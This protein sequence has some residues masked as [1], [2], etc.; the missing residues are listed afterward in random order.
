MSPNE[1]AALQWLLY[2]ASKELGS[3]RRLCKM[4]GSA[5]YIQARSQ[6]VDKDGAKTA[7]AEATQWARDLLFTE[8]DQLS[9]LLD[10]AYGD[11]E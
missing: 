7:A 9:A 11:D 4:I 1:L 5:R 6:G 10:D 2:D 3:K 8:S